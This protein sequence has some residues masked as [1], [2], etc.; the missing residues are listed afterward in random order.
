MYFGLI[1]KLPD[2]SRSGVGDGVAVVGDRVAVVGD[3][4]AVVEERLAVVG[5]GVAV[6]EERLAVVGMVAI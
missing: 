4:V 6:V 5:D 1:T 2:E 3:G